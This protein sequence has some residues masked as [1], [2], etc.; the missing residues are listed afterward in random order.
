MIWFDAPR[1]ESPSRFAL[2]S[3]QSLSSRLHTSGT[4]GESACRIRKLSAIRQ[5]KFA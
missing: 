3:F 2:L 4:S 5:V 1:F